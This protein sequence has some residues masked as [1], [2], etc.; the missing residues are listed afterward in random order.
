MPDQ[1]GQLVTLCERLTRTAAV[2]R[3]LVVAGRHV[4]LA[5]LQDGV[6]LLCAKTLDLPREQGREMLPTLHTVLAQM[7]SLTAA[8]QAAPPHRMEPERPAPN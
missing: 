5:G 3:A 8:L 7:T 1:F 6:G 4:D 2:A